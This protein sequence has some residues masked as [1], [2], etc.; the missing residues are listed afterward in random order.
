M[1]A[2]KKA[3]KKPD[4]ALVIGMGKPKPGKDE[5]EADVE[6]EDGEDED[7]AYDDAF[8]ELAEALGVDPAKVDATRGVD[9][10][11][12]MHKLC[13]GDHESDEE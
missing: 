1:M 10:L 3:G 6:K 9:A 13:S 8:H 7:A 2:E 12:V 11:R 4:L 5:E